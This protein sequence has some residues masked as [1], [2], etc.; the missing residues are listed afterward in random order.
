MFETIKQHYSRPLSIFKITREDV[1]AVFYW[2]GIF[3]LGYLAGIPDGFVGTLKIIL[4]GLPLYVWLFHMGEE[5]K[6]A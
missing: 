5:S 1:K 3:T 4:L 6:V 2:Y